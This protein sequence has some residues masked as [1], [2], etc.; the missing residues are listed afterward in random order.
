MTLEIRCWYISELC[1][2]H[3]IESESCRNGTETNWEMYK[4]YFELFKN[5][6]KRNKMHF[7]YWICSCNM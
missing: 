3:I 4:I 2:R 6:I 7:A 1:N 5:Q